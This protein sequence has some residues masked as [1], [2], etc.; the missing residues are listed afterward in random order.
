MMKKIVSV[1]FAMLIAISVNAQNKFGLMGGINASTSSA[2]HVDWRIGGFIGGVYDIPLTESFYL[3]P[4]LVLSY[5]ENEHSP[6]FHSQWN[7]SIPVLA[8]YKMRL[9]NQTALRLN[10]GPYIQYAVFGREKPYQPSDSS[11]RWWHYDFGDKITYGGQ[12][13]LQ[14]EYKKF[15]TTIDFKHSFRRNK[16]NMDGFENTIQVGIGYKF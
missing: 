7:A 1:M 10:A 9:N 14:V 2:D 6:E 8:S 13:G 12:V 3:Q 15:F 5:Q 4:R 16:L 11:L